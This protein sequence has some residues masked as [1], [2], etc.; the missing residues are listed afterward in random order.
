MAINKLAA[1]YP[2]KKYEMQLFMLAVK[3]CQPAINVYVM[4]IKCVR[5][6]SAK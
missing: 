5:R 3:S 2:S 6:L 4:A 1:K